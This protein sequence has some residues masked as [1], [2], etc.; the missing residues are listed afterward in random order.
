M[1]HRVKFMVTAFAAA[2]LIPGYARAEEKHISFGDQIK[3]PAN[4]WLKLGFTKVAGKSYEICVVPNDGTD[5]DLYTSYITWADKTPGNIHKSSALGSGKA[6]CVSFTAS[7]GG[8]YY[9][10]IFA[11]NTATNC[12]F[13]VVEK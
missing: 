12:K 11:Y 4:G 3:L 7:S 8:D 6:D 13:W 2:L 5:P 9:F 10:S 1:T